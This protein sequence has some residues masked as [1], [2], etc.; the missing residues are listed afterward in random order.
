MQ[1]DYFDILHLQPGRYDRREIDRQ[2][3]CI[4]REIH[5][6][7]GPDRQRRL[8]DALIARCVLASSARQAQL[9][10]RRNA[11]VRN[12]PHRRAAVVPVRSGAATIKSTQS[13]TR[14]VTKSVGS[15]GPFAQP[16][17]DRL[18]AGADSRAALPAPFWSRWR[19]ACCDTR[20]AS[21][22]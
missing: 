10:E 21:D 7:G 17:A 13:V 16:V 12:Q 5:R 9:V 22:C 11:A 6:A 14:P 1:A 15:F 3:D 20:P 19:T 8:D 4:R 2:Y 18:Q